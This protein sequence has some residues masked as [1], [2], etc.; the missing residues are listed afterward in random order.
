MHIMRTFPR[1]S[2]IIDVKFDYIECMKTI[3]IGI[4]PKAKFKLCLQTYHISIT[5]MNDIL[6]K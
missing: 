2:A 3:A 6:R 5:I 1:K 4:L